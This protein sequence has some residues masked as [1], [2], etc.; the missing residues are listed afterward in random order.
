MN[1]Y[2]NNLPLELKTIIASQYDYAN[3]KLNLQ[4]AK[5]T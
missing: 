5:N 1:K 2:F 4:H 3:L